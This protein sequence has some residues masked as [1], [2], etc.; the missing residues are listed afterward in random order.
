MRECAGYKKSNTRTA[1]RE[2]MYIN[3]YSTASATKEHVS[4]REPPRQMAWLK[5][6]V[7]KTL[8]KSRG[9]H[10]VRGGIIPGEHRFRLRIVRV[11]DNIN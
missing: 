4:L 3:K 8:D 5:L 10:T 6:G 9:F 11:I 2:A 1:I 7:R